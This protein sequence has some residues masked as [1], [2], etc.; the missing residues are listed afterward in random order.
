[1]DYEI[2]TLDEKFVAGVQTVTNNSAADMQSKIGGLWQKLYS[3]IAQSMKNRTNRK[4]IGVY[5]D[6]QQNG[7][8]TVLAGCEI[9]SDGI[10]DAEKSALSVKKIS[11]GKYA[12]FVVKGDVQK[13]VGNAWG[14]IWKTPLERIFTG[15]F[16]EYQEDTESG[17]GTIIIYIAVR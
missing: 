11:G 7:D 13:A 3:G 4:A 12:K 8:Y 5:G 17:S 10:I 2:V 16:E 6:Y 9:K 15:D 1:M 14:E